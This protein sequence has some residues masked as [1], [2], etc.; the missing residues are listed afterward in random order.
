MTGSNL[1]IPSCSRRKKRESKTD[2]G[3]VSFSSLSFSSP[4]ALPPPSLVP[5]YNLGQECFNFRD[6]FCLS[7]GAGWPV[8]QTMRCDGCKTIKKKKEGGVGENKEEKGLTLLDRFNYI[9]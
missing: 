4:P 9:E 2:T 5:S 7:S 1:H 3:C 6:S 8:V